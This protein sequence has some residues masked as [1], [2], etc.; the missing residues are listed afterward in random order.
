LPISAH[1]SF[2]FSNMARSV[3]SGHFIATRKRGF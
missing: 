3:I 2:S 1:I